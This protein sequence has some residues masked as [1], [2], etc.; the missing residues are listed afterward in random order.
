MPNEFGGG[1]VRSFGEAEMRKSDLFLCSALIVVAVILADAAWEFLFEDW[2]KSQFYPNATLEARQSAWWDFLAVL[3]LAL[4]A[5][6]VAVAL[7]VLAQRR[8]AGEALRESEARFRAVVENSP[9][10]IFLKDTGGR[11]LLAN[12]KYR[13]WYQ[14]DVLGKTVHDFFPKELADFFLASDR[15]VVESRSARD[16]EYDV[17][18]ADGTTHTKLTVKF[19]VAVGGIATD[20]TAR[21]RA[22][23]ALRAAH[24]ELEKRVAERT[25]D[26]RAEIAERQRVEKALRE[27]EALWRAFLDHSPAAIALKDPQGR[28]ILVNEQFAKWN[29]VSP[30][31]VIGKT[32]G[33]VF[34]EETAERVSDQDRVVLETHAPEERELVIRRPDG[35]VNT[36]L[37]TKFPVLGEDGSV[38]GIGGIASNIDERKRAE[39][40]LRQAKEQA[41]AANRAKSEFLA[42]MSHDLRTPMNA[43]LGFGQLL[44]Y[45]TKEP[46]T[47]QQ[48]EYVGFI[49]QGGQNLLE[50]INEILDLARIE[51]GKIV[52]THTDVAL[53][54]VIEENLPLVR[55]AAEKRGIELVNHCAARRLPRLRADYTR[56]KQVLLNLLSNAVKYN[57][58]GGTGTLD[59]RKAPAGLLR[60]SVADTGHG[61]P[62]ELRDQVFRPFSRLGAE[63]TGIE[64]TG[65]GLSICKRLVEAMGGEIG[66]ETRI[67]QGTTFWVDLPLA[68]VLTP[69]KSRRK[70]PA[71]P[72]PKRTRTVLYVEDELANRQF[73]EAIVRRLPDTTL[74]IADGAHRGL[75]LAAKH[76]PD[77]IVMDANP[78]DMSVTETLAR[79]RRYESTRATP[80]IAMSTEAI[81][82]K[83]RKGRRAGFLRTVAKPMDADEVV[84]AI[85]EVFAKS[86]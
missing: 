60:V 52:L 12:R 22:E 26:L 30:A 11:Y 18:H 32:V 86:P 1:R 38:A 8:R 14:S 13:D 6:S 29:G 44:A 70:G 56:F 67:G 71:R 31:E 75:R 45:D 48:R 27:S 62:P 78:R 65:L 2:V 57:R 33:D 73:M 19:P 76:A 79:L 54:E 16:Y 83:V 3:A 40:K 17:K 4:T 66:F 42:N 85:M 68:E 50:L 81:S 51:A 10:A 58:D 39:E 82:G 46:L 55:Q 80:V 77:V 7:M 53:D 23:D 25:A 61:I 41:E 9:T 72:A 69:K 20:I 49:L 84:A 24:D 43:I 64:G 63:T 74:L 21:K 37:S 47:P 34:P 59:C 15:E 36:V 35:R 5:V 28:Y